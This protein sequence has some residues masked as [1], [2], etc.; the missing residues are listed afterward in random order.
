M[1][2][3]EKKAKIASIPAVVDFL[4]FI[5]TRDQFRR[6]QLPEVMKKFGVVRSRILG[7]TFKV[8]TSTQA[9][10][11]ASFKT[12]PPAFLEL[13]KELVDIEA[14]AANALLIADARFFDLN[15]SKI[16]ENIYLGSFR[17]ARDKD[18]L[19]RKYGITH[20]VN[21][22]TDDNP[23]PEHFLYHH[24]TM[25]DDARQD[26]RHQLGGCIAFIDEAVEHRGRVLIYSDRGTSRSAALTIAYL[27]YS[28]QGMSVHEAYVFVKDRRY[29]VDP[30]RS[31]RRQLSQWESSGQLEELR[32]AL[33]RVS[34][35]PRSTS[36]YV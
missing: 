33:G 19:K 12:D 27:M 10:S 32:L 23:W 15:P 22:T 14:K 21:G 28:T 8:T 1:I 24:V 18:L 16:T 2:P 4:Y 9:S 36:S 11:P 3:A 26:I 20:V 5:C 13:E 6:P 29:I 17:A 31:F 25:T 34:N 35:S 30:N 7:E